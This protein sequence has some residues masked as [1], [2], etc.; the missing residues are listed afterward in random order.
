MYKIFTP[1]KLHWGALGQS[2]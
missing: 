2:K 1:G